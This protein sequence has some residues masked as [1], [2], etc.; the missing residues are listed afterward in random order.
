[1]LK[2]RNTKII[3]LISLFIFLSLSLAK[4]VLAETPITLDKK[5]RAGCLACHG[6]PKIHR[7]VNGKKESLYISPERF[8]SSVHKERSCLDC[9][10]DWE[11]RTHKV[12]GGGYK[13]T[14]GLACI[15][16]H[17]HDK[18]YRDY[19]D[20]IHA[21]IAMGGAKPSGKEAKGKDAPTC[22]TCHNALEPRGIH[23]V[24]KYPKK[25]KTWRDSEYW[26]KYRFSA[27]KVCGQCHMD[28]F[29][30]FNDYYHGRAYKTKE[31]DAP[32]CWTCHNNHDIFRQDEMRSTIT[33]NN[34]PA[35]CGRCHPDPTISFTS[36]YAEMIHGRD[37]LYKKHLVLQYTRNLDVGSP[38]RWVGQKMVAVYQT[39]SGWVKSIVN[40]FFP[41]SL[42]PQ[43]T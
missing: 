11:F 31:V 30:S 14:A 33:D 36:Q 9:H 18:Q 6:D 22:G 19:R 16:C 12:K 32:T 1:M 10:T 7:V 21:R 34:L 25:P 43:K 38:F 28:R 24:K 29:K 5:G 13:K 8:Y 26:T 20:S 27:D 41:E 3:I 4:A 37:N 42:R 2:K 39:V 40:F 35:T 23:Y 17:K 15:R